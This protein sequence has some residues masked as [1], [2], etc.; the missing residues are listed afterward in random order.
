MIC[1]D[2]STCLIYWI[3]FNTPVLCTVLYELRSRFCSSPFHD[4]R[5]SIAHR[6]PSSFLAMRWVIHVL[7]PAPSCTDLWFGGLCWTRH[8]THVQDCVGGNPRS[9]IMWGGDSEQKRSTLWPNCATYGFV[10]LRTMRYFPSF[11]MTAFKF[12]DI[13]RKWYLTCFQRKLVV[14]NSLFIWKKFASARI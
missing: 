11:L 10:D 4:S 3:R 7:S 9:V 5:M 12:S 13:E 14:T 1:G 8:A 2:G 6:E